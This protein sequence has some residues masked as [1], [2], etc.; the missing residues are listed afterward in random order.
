[1]TRHDFAAELRVPEPGPI[2]EYIRSMPGTHAGRPRASSSRRVLAALPVTPDGH[3][4][5]TAHAGCLIAELD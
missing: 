1:M 4:V 2:A 5:I 3:Y